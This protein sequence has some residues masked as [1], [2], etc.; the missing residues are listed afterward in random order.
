MTILKFLLRPLLRLAFLAAVIAAM[1]WVLV[2]RPIT[3]RVND[4][5]SNALHQATAGVASHDLAVLRDRLDTAARRLDEAK[6]RR[7]RVG[8]LL[9]SAQAG[10]VTLREEVAKSKAV[11]KEIAGLLGSPSPVV[12][13]ADKPYSREVLEKDAMRTM[14][15]YEQATG[16]LRDLDGQIAELKAALARVDQYIIRSEEVLASRDSL[17]S[18][19]EGRA[20]YQRLLRDVGELVSGDEGS[21]EMRLERAAAVVSPLGAGGD[22]LDGDGSPTATAGLIAGHLQR[23]EKP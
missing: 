11:L 6:S 1:V 2:G 4:A 18:R 21:F 3:R 20:E 7:D 13:V 22:D 12:M 17:V 23:G 5:V 16:Q 10:R 9:E 14:R 19:L 8:A 15:R